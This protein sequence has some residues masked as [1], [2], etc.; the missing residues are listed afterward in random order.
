MSVLENFNERKGEN[1][2]LMPIVF[3]PMRIL[4]DNLHEDVEYSHFH[5]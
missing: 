5:H 4:S 2:Q 1:Q 3:H